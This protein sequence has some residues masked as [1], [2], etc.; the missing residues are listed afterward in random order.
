MPANT[1]PLDRA[2]RIVAGIALTVLAATG[3]L[4]PWALIGVALLVTGLIG[5]CPANSLLGVKTC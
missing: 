5:W 4:R 3:T 2:L 1:G